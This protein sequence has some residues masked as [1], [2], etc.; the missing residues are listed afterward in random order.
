MIVDRQTAC[1]PLKPSEKSGF[2][3]LFFAS[4]ALLGSLRGLCRVALNFEVAVS[5]NCRSTIGQEM[6][7]TSW[8][9]ATN[10]AGRVGA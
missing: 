7:E 2:E 10:Q 6:L 5:P 4:S 8:F 1:K 3:T 9:S